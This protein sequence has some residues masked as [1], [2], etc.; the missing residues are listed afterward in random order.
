MN[1]DI[2]PRRLVLRGALALGCGLCLPV[3]LSGC[4][5]KPG[6]SS[7]PAGAASPSP[8]PGAAPA[9]A[10]TPVAPAAKMTQANA[11]YQPRP[12]GD[13]K[14]GNCANLIAESNTCKLVDG[15]VSPEGWCVIWT[16]KA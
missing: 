3:A 13:Q 14:C 6:G 1:A 15:Q 16:K 10:P 8:A 5:S 9:A 2:P 12:K 4:D 11:Q 7:A